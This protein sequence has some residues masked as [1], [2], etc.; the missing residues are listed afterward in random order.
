MPVS[1]GAVPRDVFHG[2]QLEVHCRVSAQAVDQR[3][4][5]ADAVRERVL[6]GQE[7]AC[8]G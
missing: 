3:D 1:S 6:T 2:T 5:D 7:T 8:A 4:H